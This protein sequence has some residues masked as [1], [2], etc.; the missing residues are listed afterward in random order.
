MN[1]PAARAFVG[2]RPVCEY[3]FQQFTKSI[4]SWYRLIRSRSLGIEEK[5][6]NPLTYPLE[7]LM[8]IKKNRFDQAVKVLEEKK[9]VLEKAYDRL[10]TL[11]QERDETLKHKMA[12][13]AQLRNALDEGTIPIKSSR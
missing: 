1:G 11:T 7:Q 12:K 4:R 5:N 8:I 2:N 10:Y 3:Q 13:L 9:L 6:M